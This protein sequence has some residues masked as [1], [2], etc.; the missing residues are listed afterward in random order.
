MVV[1]DSTVIRGLITRALE[2]DPAIKVIVS[3]ADGEMALRNVTKHPVEVVVLDIE[4]PVMDGITALPKLLALNPKLK[5]LMASTLTGRNAEISLKA[6]ELGAADY[7]PKPSSTRAMTDAEEFKRELVSKVK[8]LGASSRRWQNVRATPNPIA[9]TIDKPLRDDEVQT[10][11]TIT[12]HKPPNKLKGG[13][14]KALAIGSSTGGPQALFEVMKNLKDLPIPIF[15]TQH[16]PPTFTTILAQH[17]AR[18]TGVPCSEAIEGEIARPGHAYLAPGDQHLTLRLFG[19]DVRVTLSN[20]PPENFCRPAVDPMLR[21]L[22][23]V[24]SGALVLAILTG[25]GS[26]GTKGAA[27]VVNAG[28]EVIAQDEATSVVWGMPGS[29][30]NAGLASSI[31]PVGEIGPYLRNKAMAVGITG[32]AR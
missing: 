27:E 14:P 20:G 9:A 2:S 17:I 26:D 6:M 4:M 1:D 25:M 7:V 11:V 5:I 16:M 24:Y 10:A 29:V 15:I 8:A 3:V 12:H 32:S 23:S 21:S 13:P 22:V 19:G 30:V 18:Q 31:L 28:G